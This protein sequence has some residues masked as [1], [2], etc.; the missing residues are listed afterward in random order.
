M[1][2]AIF[3]IHNDF[4][5]A[6]LTELV[7]KDDIYFEILEPETLRYTFRCR[8][9]LNFGTHFKVEYSHINLVVVEPND[10]CSTAANRFELKNNIGLIQRGGCSFLAKCIEAERNGMIAII[11]YDNN[12]S[13]DDLYIEMVGDTTSRNCSIPAAFL[14]GKDGH[15]IR[16]AL[17]ALNLNRAIINIPINISLVPYNRRQPPWVVW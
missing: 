13:N 16:R 2:F 3:M 4:T 9:A 15:M 5:E 6:L 11:I 14:L 12:N 1:N 8:L 7:S 17:D 10:A